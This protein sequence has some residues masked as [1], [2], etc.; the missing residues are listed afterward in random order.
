MNEKTL[1]KTVSLPFGQDWALY[2]DAN[3]VALSPRLDEAGRERALSEVADHWRR[4]CLR[5]V[6]A[7][8]EATRV[9]QPLNIAQQTAPPKPTI[10]DVIE[11]L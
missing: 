4:S 2:S 7:D 10:R 5:I 8:D 1:I 9:T 6:G 3:V 11:A